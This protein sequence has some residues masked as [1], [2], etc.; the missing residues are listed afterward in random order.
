MKTILD[1]IRLCFASTRLTTGQRMAADWMRKSQDISKKLVVHLER[2][3]DIEAKAAE[4]S[5]TF[6]N[7]VEE[8]TADVDATNKLQK[9]QETVI[10]ALRSENKILGEV[11]LPAM[12]AALKLEMERTRAEIDLQVRR[13][14]AARSTREEER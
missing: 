9:Q 3:H 12:T 14:V 11:Q 4:I 7:Y 10:D 5:T 13:Q 6:K 1:R 8:I 2:L